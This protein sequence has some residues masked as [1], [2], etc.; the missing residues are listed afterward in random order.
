MNIIHNVFN[1][2]DTDVAMYM[3]DQFYI[4]STT[5][6]TIYIVK[7]EKSGLTNVLTYAIIIILGNVTLKNKTI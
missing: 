5:K 4:Y 1:L 3:Y 2:C 7:D 6:H